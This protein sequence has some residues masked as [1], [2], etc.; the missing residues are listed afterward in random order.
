MTLTTE[1]GKAVRAAAARYGRVLQAGSQQRSNKYFRKAAE[2]VRNG[3]IGKVLTISTSSSG[4]WV[5]TNPARSCSFRKATMAAPT[6]S[7]AMRTVLKSSAT[8][9]PGAGLVTRASPQGSRLGD[10]S[11]GRFA[12]GH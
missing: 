6:K 1:E 11:Q 4:R 8:A 7:T 9:D 12:D 5:W 3:Y 10:G 2:L